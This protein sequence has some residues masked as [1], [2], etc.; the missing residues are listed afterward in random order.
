[1]AHLTPAFQAG[2]RFTKP[3]GKF[4]L[5]IVAPFKPNPIKGYHCKADQ[6]DSLS[7]SL[8]LSLSPPLSFSL[9]L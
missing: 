5:H 8:S 6:E 2:R 3:K 9:S 1:M 7:L 4:M